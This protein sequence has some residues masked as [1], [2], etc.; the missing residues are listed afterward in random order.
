MTDQIH[1]TRLLPGADLTSQQVQRFLNRLS[2]PGAPRPLVFETWA[3]DDSIVHLLGRAEPG[4][5]TMRTLL[6]AHLP[7]ARTIRT[8]RPE[9]P[10]RIA[11]LRLSPR[12]MPLRDDALNDLLHA[13]YSV[14]SG[15]RKGETIALQVVVGRGR[16]PSVVPTKLQ[17]PSASIPELLLRGA[18]TASSDTRRRMA[19]HAGQAR[20][21]VTVRIGVTA[22]APERRQQIRGQFLSALEQLEAPGVQL[23]LTNESPR[24][25]EHASTGWNPLV[26]TS[27]QLSGLLAWPVDELELPGLP[28]RHPR[29]I[30]PPQGITD[31]VSVFASATAPGTDRC[32]GMTPDARLLHLAITGGTG[33]GK[34]EIFAHLA[35]SDIEEGRPLVLIEPKRQLVDAIVKREPK[36]AAGRIVV[37]DAAEPNPV[38]F[39]PLDIGERDPGPAVDGILEV[40]KAVFTDGWGPRTEDLLH[41]GLL[42]LEADGQRRGVPHTL[43]DL[44]KLLSDDGYRRG[45]IGA[46]ADDPVLAAYWATFNELSPANR[47]NIVAAPLNKLRKYVLRKNIAAVLGQ[48]SPKFRLRDIWRD[49]EPKAVLVPLNDALVGPGASQLLGGLI[50]AS[51]WIATQERATEDDPR[52]RPGFVFVD[53]VQRYLRLPTSIED[54]YATSRSYGI[55]WHTAFQGRGLVPTSL[56]DA[57]E[58]NARNLITFAASPKD[59]TALAKTTTK[60]KPED[61]QSLALRHIY[62]NL[63]TDGAPAG[64]FSAKTNPPVADSGN[65]ELIRAAYRERF[66]GDEATMSPA[67]DAASL[68]VGGENEAPRNQRRRRS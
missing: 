26:L 21:D 22:A 67:P 5:P 28:P 39:N 18:G 53:E 6:R 63:V 68:F 50:V 33:S 15:R 2:A 3:V 40:F 7:D 47:A 42:T 52:Q 11:R 61:F 31:K 41:A 64:W 36:E 29:L 44:P 32:I 54:A 55:G 48:S 20:L 17:D 58:L 34:S 37:I 49:P 35:L 66:A 60:L 45:V 43:L 38:G 65:G 30:P 24:K 57:I 8:T 16:R 27:P 56:V 10:E 23:S 9:A 59:A 14:F 12:A 13:I 25:W 4:K 51:L 1:Y 46:V 19:Q 62:C